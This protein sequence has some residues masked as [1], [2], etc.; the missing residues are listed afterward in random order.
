VT[1]QL[2]NEAGAPVPDGTPGELYI[3][4]AGVARGY[5][6]RPE[7]TAEKFVPDPSSGGGTVY[8]SG[9]LARR[10]PDGVIE[11]L[12]RIDGQFKLRGYRVEPGEIENLLTSHPKVKRAAA[13]IRH[14]HLGD[15]RLV[16]YVVLD[17]GEPLDRRE[18]RAY[19]RE[20]LPSYMVPAVF[21]ALPELPI[22]L[23]GKTDRKALP[24]P[25]W[26]RKGIY[27]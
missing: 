15:A 20:R 1:V 25:D 27:V 4:G 18:L 7:L 5:W 2:V 10:R 3:G 23:N 8:R 13:A 11:F 21:L 17:G 22:T 9:D 19:V 6:D 12:G 24:D 26:K 14:N 16:A